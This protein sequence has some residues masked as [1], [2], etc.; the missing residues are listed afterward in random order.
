MTPRRYGLVVFDFDGTL[1]DSFPWFTSVINDVADRYGFRRIAPHESERLRGLDARAIVHHLGIPAWKL[2]FITRHMHRLA[3][4]DIATIPL[5][6]GMPEV[7]A[8]LH[9]EGSALGIVSSNLEANI[10]Q[11]LGPGKAEAVRHYACG[12]SLF[13]KARRLGA[14]IR[15][16]GHAPAETLYVGDEIRD[17]VAAT[18]VG[19]DFG[20]VNWGYTT[21]HALAARGP[22]H[23]FT[24][25][26]AI[27]AAT[28]GVS[29]VP[30]TAGKPGM[31]EENGLFDVRHPR[32]INH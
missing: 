22:A 15:A 30:Q 9:R 24:H 32:R 28:T 3:T 11:A 18:E 21:G 25:P 10:R 1:A 27:L 13:G 5:F 2:P 19:C 4:R 29:A 26:A 14:L 7:L 16:A 6:A 17:H 12:A 8:T 20:A 31:E 23:L